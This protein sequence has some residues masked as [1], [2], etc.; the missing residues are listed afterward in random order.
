[1]SEIKVKQNS[2]RNNIINLVIKILDQYTRENGYFSPDDTIIN[3]DEIYESVIYPEY[4]FERYTNIDLGFIENTEEKILGKTIPKEKVILIDKSIAP[5]SGDPRYV[6]T[7]AHE[8]AHA[9]LHSGLKPLFRCTSKSIKKQTDIYEKQANYCAQ[10]LLMPKDLVFYRFVKYYMPSKPIFYI[11]EGTYCLGWHG[12]GKMQYFDSYR[13]YCKALA[14]PLRGYF[15]NIS[16]E[17]LGGRLCKLGLI[18]NRTNETYF[19]KFCKHSISEIL[20][21]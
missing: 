16:M 18:Q 10:N 11:G 2:G 14:R 13:D 4:E 12:R 17:S 5:E 15:S 8:I 1:M 21:A 20:V 19:D 7:L 9:L 3:I 6:F